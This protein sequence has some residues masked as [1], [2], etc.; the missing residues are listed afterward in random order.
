MRPFFYVESIYMY[1]YTYVAMSLSFYYS[2]FF[3][4]LFI[5]IFTETHA[6]RFDSIE[7]SLTTRCAG[8]LCTS[9]GWMMYVYMYMYNGATCEAV[10][11]CVNTQLV[12]KQHNI[13]TIRQDQT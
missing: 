2:V 1:I 8:C 3:S 7:P 6:H 11:C 13:Q 4:T 12:C 10:V 9:S 5:C